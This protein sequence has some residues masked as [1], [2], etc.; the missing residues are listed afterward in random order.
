MYFGADFDAVNNGEQDTF[1]E[2]TPLTFHVIDIPRNPSIDLT[3]GTTYYWRID[4]VNDLHPDSPWK[5]DVWSFWLAPYTA[6]DPFPADGAELIDPNITLSWT[7]GFNTKLHTL[8][9]GENSADVGT[10]AVGT[11]KGRLVTTKY[12]SDALESGKTYYWR[13]DEFDGAA[14]HKGEI[15]SFSTKSDESELGHVP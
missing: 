2:N 7:A 14:T 1:L 15:W 11:H 10:G 4:E 5:G 12:L 6:Y 13:V 3:A 8:Y 9:L